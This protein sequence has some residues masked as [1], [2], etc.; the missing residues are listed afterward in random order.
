MNLF[1]PGRMAMFLTNIAITI[2]GWGY[3]TVPGSTNLI[4]ASSL[5]VQKP[6]SL[7]P[8]VI[9]EAAMGRVD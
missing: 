3:C 4:I 7:Q 9:Y 8:W 6:H 2:N 1:Q 5:K